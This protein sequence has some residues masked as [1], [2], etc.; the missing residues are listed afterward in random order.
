LYAKTPSEMADIQSMCWII[1]ESIDLEAILKKD[2]PNFKYK[3]DYF[4][5]FILQRGQLAP[6]NRKAEGDN[7]YQRAFFLSLLHMIILQSMHKTFEGTFSE[8]LVHESSELG[9]HKSS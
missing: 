1:P 4:Y 2:P 8:R 9:K 6:I 5:Y 7:P 3:I